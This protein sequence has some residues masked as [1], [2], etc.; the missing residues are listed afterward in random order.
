MVKERIVDALENN[1]EDLS[2]EGC[3][4]SSCPSLLAEKYSTLSLCRIFRLSFRFRLSAL[5]ALDLSFNQ[6]SQWPELSPL[7]HL[8]QLSLNGNLLISI[9]LNTS[10]Y[11]VYFIKML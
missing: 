4:L 11:I 7:V 10:S 8:Q 5:T 6:F 3:G 2:L 9:A 1:K